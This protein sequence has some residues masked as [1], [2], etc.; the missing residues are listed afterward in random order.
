D[1]RGNEAQQAVQDKSDP[2]DAKGA[3]ARR[4]GFF[5]GEEFVLTAVDPEDV[6]AA[7]L[8]TVVQGVDLY[9]LLLQQVAHQDDEPR[10]SAVRQL[11]RVE[12]EDSARRLIEDYLLD[13]SEI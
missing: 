12:G 7:D 3:D 2:L 8:E 10:R 11:R 13:R 5:A 4:R 6:G 9:T 1:F